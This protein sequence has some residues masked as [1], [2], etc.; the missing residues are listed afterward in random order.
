MIVIYVYPVPQNASQETTGQQTK[1]L[2]LNNHIRSPE[3]KR[4]REA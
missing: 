3:K 2:I 4:K 1:E